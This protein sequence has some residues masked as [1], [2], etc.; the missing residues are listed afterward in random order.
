MLVH[1]FGSCFYT[2]RRNIGPLSERFR[3]IAVD[4]PGFGF[5][6]RP[7]GFSY[8]LWGYVWFMKRLFETLDLTGVRLVG[9]SL[10]GTI[11]LEFCRRYGPLVESLVLAATPIAGKVNISEKVLS[12]LLL[13]SYYD[14]SFLTDD[15]I[16]VFQL[17]NP[18]KAESP[19]EMGK[20]LAAERDSAGLPK[21]SVP[22]LIVWGEE[23]LVLPSQ[24]ALDLQK[25]F[26]LATHKV[27][28]RC[29]HAPHEEKS[30]EF[31]DLVLGHFCE[32][33]SN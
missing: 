17:T 3:V 28:P 23:D 18:P 12:N 4:L 7:E 20:I 32:G 2:W 33:C 27:M 15:L 21:L 30:A 6:E 31:N 5:S 24:R 22:C 13:Y 10:G 14:K 29:G 16:Q 19:A 26:R 11:C 9:H 1:G 8:S 25:Q